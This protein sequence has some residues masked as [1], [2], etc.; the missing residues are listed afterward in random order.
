VIGTSKWKETE[1]RI[2]VPKAATGKRL[3]AAGTGQKGGRGPWHVENPHFHG[4]F[5]A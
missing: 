3:T 5:A 2:A 1:Q 4:V